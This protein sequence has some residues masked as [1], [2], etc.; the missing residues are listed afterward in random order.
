[1]SNS[2]LK[3]SP[4]DQE[5]Q[6]TLNT[7]RA[8][9]PDVSIEYV[10]LKNQVTLLFSVVSRHNQHLF[11]TFPWTVG[12]SEG[13]LEEVLRSFAVEVQ[14]YGE[15]WLQK[16][17]AP[18]SRNARVREFRE[19]LYPAFLRLSQSFPPGA[20]DRLNCTSNTA[21]S[22]CDAL[23]LTLKFQASTPDEA[24]QEVELL[25]EFARV[26]A[27]GKKFGKKS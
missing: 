21:L 14:A 13:S 3:S 11:R 23:E 2:N 15:G 19:T 7:I 18:I 8:Q 9:F 10:Q 6:E 12:I 20:L 16:Q 24:L 25:R 27:L 22:D 5:V 26:L 17:E 1:M 4:V